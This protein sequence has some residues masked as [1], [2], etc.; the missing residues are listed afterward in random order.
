MN[1]NSIHPSWAKQLN[2]EFEQKYMLDLD[3]FLNK[4][5]KEHRVF[6]PEE[7]VFAAFESA[8]SEVKVVILGQDPYHGAGQAHGLSFSVPQGIGIPPSLRNMYKELQSDLQFENPG[9]GDLTSWAKQ[10]VLLLNTT[11]TV[12]EKE[13][14]SHAGQ[15]WEIFTDRVI[16]ILNESC[17]KLV[18]L[19]WGA[20]AQSKKKLI[21]EQKHCI[22]EAVHP[23]PLSAHRGFL[24]CK[25]FSKANDYLVKTG[26]TPI[27]WQIEFSLF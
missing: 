19:L 25:H 3:S 20:H 12:R 14:K 27:N 26:Q 17:E 18:F 16:E 4:Q 13:A 24:G 15:G 9:H 21:D 23:S 5:S 10:G 2:S 7:Q 8:L 11:L 22:L 1:F 6:P